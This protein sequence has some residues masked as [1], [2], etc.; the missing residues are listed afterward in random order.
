M[1]HVQEWREARATKALLRFEYP[2]GGFNGMMTRHEAA[3]VIGI[4]YALILI[5]LMEVFK[6]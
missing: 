5:Q 2:Q 3:S 4:E 1:H 6:R